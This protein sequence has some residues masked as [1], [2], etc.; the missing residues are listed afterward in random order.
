VSIGRR[1][2]PRSGA[3]EVSRGERG[4]PLTSSQLPIEDMNTE[5]VGLGV[6]R[7]AI[8]TDPPDRE[9]DGNASAREGSMTH[10][11]FLDVAHSVLPTPDWSSGFSFSVHQCTKIGEGSNRESLLHIPWWR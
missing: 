2:S 3:A 1:R 4:E 9:P 7:S 8:S 11:D 10:D 6:T 5:L